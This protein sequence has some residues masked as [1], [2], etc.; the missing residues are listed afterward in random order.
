MIRVSFLAR[1]AAY[2]ARF[3]AWLRLL[4]RSLESAKSKQN[5][6]LNSTVVMVPVV[7]M[8]STP[9]AAASTKLVPISVGSRSRRWTQAH[10]ARSISH[11]YAGVRNSNRILTF[12]KSCS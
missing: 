6:Q 7:T 4:A 9:A 11:S 12:P 10:P 8:T 3:K 2:V 1:A 5:W